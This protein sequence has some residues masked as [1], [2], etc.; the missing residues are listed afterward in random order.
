MPLINAWILGRNCGRG[1]QTQ[2][3]FIKEILLEDMESISPSLCNAHLVVFLEK[4]A[5]CSFCLSR[6]INS[7]TAYMC[8]K[9]NV[10]LHPKCFEDYH[11][12]QIRLK[13]KHME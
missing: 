12:R 7:N 3:D 1:D 10:A 4:I 2:N 13:R 5:K 11:K 9:C 6:K 8:L